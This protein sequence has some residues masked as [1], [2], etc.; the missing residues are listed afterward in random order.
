MLGRGSLKECHGFLHSILGAWGRG[1]LF[2]RRVVGA[3]AGCG[4]YIGSV[5]E[6]LLSFC[7]VDHV[8]SPGF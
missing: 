6:R 5:E 2:H 1:L 7:F 8:A 3:L 4:G